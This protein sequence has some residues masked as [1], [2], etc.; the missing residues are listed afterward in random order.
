MLLETLVKMFSRHRDKFSLPLCGT[1]TTDVVSDQADVAPGSVEPKASIARSGVH[2]D[3]ITVAQ[4][5]HQITVTVI[6]VTYT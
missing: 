3:M 2:G 6:T 4:V 5:L 1:S